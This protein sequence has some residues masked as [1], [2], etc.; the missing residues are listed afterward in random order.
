MHH[1]EW[2][3]FLFCFVRLIGIFMQ[4][5][6]VCIRER[7]REIIC[8]WIKHTMNIGGTFARI[9]SLFFG[10]CNLLPGNNENAMNNLFYF[11]ENTELLTRNRKQSHQTTAHSNS[12]YQTNSFW[13]TNFFNE[14]RFLKKLRF[15]FR[16]RISFQFKRFLSINK[17]PHF[18]D[19]KRSVIWEKLGKSEQWSIRENWKNRAI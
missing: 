18:T 3:V 7:K 9:I 6:I 2:L 12:Y 4:F 16:Y 14:N 1:D 8:Y 11:N 15:V 13:M 17:C 19:S 5:W 10:R